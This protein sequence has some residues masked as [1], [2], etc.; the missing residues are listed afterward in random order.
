MLYHVSH[1]CNTFSSGTVVTKKEP[2]DVGMEECGRVEALQS[3]GTGD[4]AGGIHASNTYLL[5]PLICQA[6]LQRLRF[7]EVREVFAL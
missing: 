5:S 4:I 3:R 2:W 1:I 7:Y 6:L